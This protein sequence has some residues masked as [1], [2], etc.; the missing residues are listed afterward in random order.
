MTVW[1]R[2]AAPL[3]TVTPAP[4]QSAMWDAVTVAKPPLRR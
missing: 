4:P 2:H 1:L 3:A